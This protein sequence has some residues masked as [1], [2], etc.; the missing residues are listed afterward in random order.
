M[1]SDHICARSKLSV[2]NYTKTSHSEHPVSFV[3]LAIKFIRARH[4]K[5]HDFEDLFV[6]ARVGISV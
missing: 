6:A 2:R 3:I 1:I 5:F 4:N